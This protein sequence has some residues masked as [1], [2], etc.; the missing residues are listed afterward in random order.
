MMT[1]EEC[2]AN[3][4]DLAAEAI[5]HPERAEELLLMAH[6]WDQVADTADWQEKHGLN[7][8]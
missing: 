3:S 2:R 5:A 6:Q 8:L 7:H 1:A 4:K